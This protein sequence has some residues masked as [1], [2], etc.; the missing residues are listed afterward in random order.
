MVG[1]LLGNPYFVERMGARNDGA[2]KR[3]VTALKVA[4]DGK[5]GGISKSSQKYLSGLYK[6][7]VKAVDDEEKKR[8]PRAA[9]GR[10]NQRNN[11]REIMK[12]V[13]FIHVDGQR[14]RMPEEA[15]QEMARKIEATKEYLLSKGVDKTE[16][17][18]ATRY[19]IVK[20][21]E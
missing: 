6:A 15:A 10:I 19:Q 20:D 4:H 14:E 11:R 8:P 7:Y 17:E 16:L 1:D 2:W 18:N 5:A 9:R 3:F 13:T 21:E 12:M